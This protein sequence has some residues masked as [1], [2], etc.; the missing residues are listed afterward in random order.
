MRTWQQ[1]RAMGRDP[2]ARR[3]FALEAVED[4][5]RSEEYRTAV[6]A[7]AYYGGENPTIR[8]YEKLVYDLQGVG[9]RNPYA[10]NHKIASGFFTFVVDQ[11]VGYLLGNGVGFRLPETRARLGRSFDLD[12]MDLLEFARV[13]GV[14]YGFWNHDHL[15][16]FR[17]TEFVPLPDEDTGRLRAGIRFWRVGPESEGRPLRMTLYEEEGYTEMR[18]VG[19]GD[20]TAGERRPY[21][22]AVTG[23]PADGPGS[24]EGRNYGALPIVPLRANRQGRSA[25]VGRRNTLDALDLACSNMV[26]DVDEGNLIYWVLVNAGGMDDLDDMMFVNRLHALRVAHVDGDAGAS[27]TPH[28]VEAPFQ[29]SAAAIDMLLRRLYDDFQAFNAAAVAASNQSATAIRASYAPLDLKTDKL[30]REVTRFIHG[31][32]ALLGVDDD[33]SYTR[34]QL[35]N[36]LEEIQALSQAA[37]FLGEDYTRRRMLS[38]LGEIDMTG[39]GA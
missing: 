7:Q 8:R 5:C 25:L 39:D 23:C 38:V 12:L 36:R 9:H 30:E 37:P 22:T 26:N 17:L 1:L 21:L 16:L 10:P 15:E 13:D 2:E 6:A 27:A 28:T 19:G 31:I 34:N 3:R 33:P 29:S 20:V 24:S 35:I 18:R 32:L 11:E 4:H 14:S